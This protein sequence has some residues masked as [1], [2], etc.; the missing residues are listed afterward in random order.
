VQVIL[1]IPGNA[2]AERMVATP[3]SVR[4]V[5]HSGNAG[6]HA[7][8]ELSNRAYNPNC[9]FQ[10]Q[11]LRKEG[12]NV[13]TLWDTMAEIQAE[14]RE[15]HRYKVNVDYAYTVKSGKVHVMCHEVY[16]EGIREVF[17]RFGVEVETWH[18]YS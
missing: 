17:T 5:Q 15:P 2:K 8:R 11:K 10:K 3:G 12:V 7:N 14:L 1:K 9:C 16:Q 13:K 6:K 4:F 18:T